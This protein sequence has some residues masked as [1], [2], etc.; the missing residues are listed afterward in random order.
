MGVQGTARRQGGQLR[1]PRLAI[2]ICARC[3]QFVFRVRDFEEGGRAAARQKVMVGKRQCLRLQFPAKFFL[4]RCG[5]SFR[6]RHPEAKSRPGRPRPRHLCRR[7]RRRHVHLIAD[8]PFYV[9]AQYAADRMRVLR[10]I[11]GFFDASGLCAGLATG[12]QG[13]TPSSL[14]AFLQTCCRAARVAAAPQIPDARTDV[15][16]TLLAAGLRMDR[17]YSF[18]PVLSLPG[19]MRSRA[20]CC[21]HVSR[22][23]WSG[24]AYGMARR[25]G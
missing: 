6:L 1:R 20:P 21:P 2:G 9:R 18:T 22:P 19:R 12:W 11:I 17:R 14:N 23:D 7:L 5:S 8:Q 4:L 25:C 13:T 3:A 16:Q 24:G 15:G 10:L